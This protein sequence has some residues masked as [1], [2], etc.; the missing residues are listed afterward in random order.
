MSKN[1]VAKLIEEKFNGKIPNWQKGHWGEGN[2][3]NILFCEDNIVLYYKQI[4]DVFV[5]RKSGKN[6]ELIPFHYKCGNEAKVL[7]VYSPPFGSKHPGEGYE[8]KT[9]YIFY[10]LD[11]NGK[12]KYG[13]IHDI[14]I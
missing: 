9:N 14:K 8:G 11:Y 6:K 5:Q 1:L 2:S 4:E 12:P 13:E 3:I 7:S 10:C